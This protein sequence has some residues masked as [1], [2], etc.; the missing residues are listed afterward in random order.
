MSTAYKFQVGHTVIVN[1]PYRTAMIDGEEVKLSGRYGTITEIYNIGDG[2]CQVE[3]VLKGGKHRITCPFWQLAPYQKTRRDRQREEAA[4]PKCR[5][6]NTASVGELL[7][8]RCREREELARI[9]AER[10]AQWA[11]QEALR[12]RNRE[13]LFDRHRQDIRNARD[14]HDLK[15][16]MEFLLDQLEGM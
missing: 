15:G 6:G 14:V 16:A 1:S 7:C 4:K 11:A 13:A 2:G 3:F 9:Q 8:G 5:C 10:E 12:K